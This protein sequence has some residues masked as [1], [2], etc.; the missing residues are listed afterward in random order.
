MC[1]W[2]TYM[3]LGA[4]VWV[5]EHVCMHAGGDHSLMSGVLDLSIGREVLCY[6]GAHR[7]SVYSQLAPGIPFQPPKHWD[8]RRAAKQDQILHGCWGF[9]LVSLHLCGKRCIPRAVSLSS[10]KP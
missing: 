1:V 2:C 4:H 9:E 6:P 7:I 10:P 8:Y 5:L 3:S